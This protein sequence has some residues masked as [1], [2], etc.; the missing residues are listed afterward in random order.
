MFAID[1]PTAV[2]TRPATGVAGTAGWF[3]EGS[4]GGG[5]PAT[6]L[7][8]DWLNGVQAELL[9]VLGAGGVAPDKAK[10]DQLLAAIRALITS[11][12]ANVNVQNTVG[13]NAV[14]GGTLSPGQAGYGVLVFAGQLTS[15][16][17]WVFPASGRW[18]INNQTSGAY[19]LI[20]KTP[21]G[22]GYKVRQGFT[23][24]L[25]ADGT[26]MQPDGMQFF[27]GTGAAPTLQPLEAYLQNS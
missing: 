10:S 4:P 12:G 1:D 17:T 14:G 7:R 13:V 21:N 9:S 20:C 5:Q 26:N 16:A 19:D 11:G 23:Y 22:A 2:S 15:A 3:S 27:S 6:L 25:Y 24:D 8:A 18:T